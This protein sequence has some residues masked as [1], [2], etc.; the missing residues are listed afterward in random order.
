MAQHVEPHRHHGEVVHETSDVNIRAILAFAAGLLAL[1]AVV[2]LVVWLL[3]GYLDRRETTAS[4]ERAYPLAVGQEDRLPPEPRLQTNPKQ[5]LRDLRAAEEQLLKGYSWVDRNA[6]V[7]RIPVDEAM[8]L[9][10]QRGLPARASTEEQV[11][12]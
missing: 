3:F 12:R 8:K 10:L 5:D 9:T 6:G 2:Y 4:R 11:V 7:V 1:G